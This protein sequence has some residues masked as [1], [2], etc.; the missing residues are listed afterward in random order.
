M[1]SRF[2]QRQ[3][4]DSSL[5]PLA[6]PHLAALEGT[7]KDLEEESLFT[8]KY[9]NAVEL[10]LTITAGAGGTEACD[11]VTMLARMYRMY[12]SSKPGWVL[13]VVAETPGPVAGHSSVEYSLSA[14]EEDRA[15][16]RLRRE[17]GAHRLVRISPF[18]SGG[19]RMTTF[20]GVAVTPV[21]DLGSVSSDLEGFETDC[22]VTTMR[23]GGKGGQN[24]NKVE[25]AV[26]ITH[27]PTG[28][29]VKCSQERTQSRNKSLAF[30][31][32]RSK[33]LVLKEDVRAETLAEISGDAVE[34]A[35]GRQIRNYVMHPYKMVKDLRSGYE[36]SDVEGVLDGKL[37]GVIESCL[38]TGEGE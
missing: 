12:C 32:I 34:A 1:R 31:L 5:L 33:L 11:W 13:T 23:A 20:A 15:Y 6:K 26:R 3:L 17:K 25:T 2:C 29:T 8:G 19:K 14:P 22:V 36:T 28:V 10:T 7:L 37:G 24:V 9:D 4:H 30:D 18:N 38:G 16:G 27:T 21:I 35:W